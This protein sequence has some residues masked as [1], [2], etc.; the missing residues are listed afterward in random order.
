MYVAS[1]HENLLGL[2]T[3]EIFDFGTKKLG[4]KILE[5]LVNQ[6]QDKELRNQINT[7]LVVLVQDNYTMNPW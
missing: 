2:V 7:S 5:M 6:I 3:F 1:Y 4:T